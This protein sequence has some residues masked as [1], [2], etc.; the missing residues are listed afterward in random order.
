ME[1]I[2]ILTSQNIEIDYALAG[3][4][5]RIKA[6]A[7]DYSLFMGIYL[8]CI[9]LFISAIKTGTT[10]NPWN[11]GI[12]IIIWLALC[13][14]YDLVCEIFFNGQSIGKRISKIKVISLNGER[15]TVSQYILRWLFR[16][17]DFGLTFGTAAVV[18]VT[19][20][21]KRQ[22]IGDIIAGTTVVITEPVTRFKDLIFNDFNL[23][24]EPTYPEVYKLT[25]QDITLIHDVLKNF[26]RTKNN[27][28]VYKLAI[29]I[30]NYLGVSYPNNINEYRFLEM[31]VHD[32]IIF[33]SQNEPK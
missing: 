25:D 26:N 33:T 19:V 6:R 24:Y 32:Y 4:G 17:I 7:I 8:I 11:L 18:F 9:G 3:L 13:V 23:D 1:T 22:R 31:I 14:F 5:K 28:L 21:E 12:A 30:K 15:P 29:K 2:K 27:L 20:S 10:A 16:I